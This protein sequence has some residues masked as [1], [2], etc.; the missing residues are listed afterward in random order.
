[1]IYFLLPFKIELF[2][3]IHLAITNL[4]KLQLWYK[5]LPHTTEDDH[6]K[7]KTRRKVIM[8]KHKYHQMLLY[9][10]LVFI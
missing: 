1:M 9:L 6:R 5:D 4:F 7:L 8:D 10:Q 3:V 2:I